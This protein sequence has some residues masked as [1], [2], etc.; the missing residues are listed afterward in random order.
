WRK[1]S[2][3]RYAQRFGH[4]GGTAF[5]AN[6]RVA[7]RGQPQKFTKVFAKNVQVN[8]FLRFGFTG[9]EH[10]IGIFFLLW[11]VIK[12]NESLGLF[13]YKINNA[14]HIVQ[15]IRFVYATS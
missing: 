13:H 1:N 3:C 8:V 2:K 15:W 6:K 12:Q 11:N 5:I 9:A 7:E 4:I 10:K 14:C